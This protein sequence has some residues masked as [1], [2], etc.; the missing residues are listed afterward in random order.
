MLGSR[1]AP[2]KKSSFSH[3][4]HTIVYS[5]LT[6]QSHRAHTLIG[7]HRTKEQPFSSSNDVN[8][9]MHILNNLLRLLCCHSNHS[10]IL[11]TMRNDRYI[12]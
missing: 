12:F 4:T 8:H 5:L 3:E 10:L 11:F 7:I 9:T 2:T 1:T 6:N